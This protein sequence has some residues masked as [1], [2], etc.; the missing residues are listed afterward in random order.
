MQQERVKLWKIYKFSRLLYKMG[1]ST[2]R[3]ITTEIFKKATN[4]LEIM[5]QELLGEKMYVQKEGIMP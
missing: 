2:Y 4:Q 3:R 1:S 5:K